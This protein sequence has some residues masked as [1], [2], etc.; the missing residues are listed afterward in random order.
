MKKLTLLLASVFGLVSVSM[1]HGFGHANINSYADAF[2]FD[3]MGVT[4]SVYPDGEFDF[5]LPQNQQSTTLSN[6]YVNVTFNSGYNYNPFVQYDD[7]GAVIQVEN[8]Q[9]WYDYYGRVSQIG[10]VRISYRDRR[11]CQVGGLY[12]HYNSYGHY[13]YH[14]GFINTWNPYFVY[15]PFY[16]AFARP[17]INLCFVRTNPYRQFYTPIRYT[18]YRPYVQNIR[19]CYATI[20]HTYR[21]PAGYGRVHHRYT[22]TAGRGEVPMVRS[23]RT[24]TTADASP[25]PS[26]MNRAA[27]SNQRAAVNSTNVRTNNGS[28]Q[29]Q[30]VPNANSGRSIQRT[31]EVR[32]PVATQPR[33]VQSAPVRTSTNNRVAP[34]TSSTRAATYSQSRGNVNAS[35]VSRPS[36]STSTRQA[37]PSRSAVSS[38][39]SRNSVAKAPT[40]S[41]TSTAR[42]QPS[43]SSRSSV[44]KPTSS[45]SSR[46]TVSKPTASPSSR[47]S[48]SQPTRSSSSVKSSGRNTSSS[49]AA[50]KLGVSKS[51]SSKRGN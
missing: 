4:F 22:Q 47:V 8:V 5:Y 18:Y 15:R 30:T 6:G 14:T 28:R 31:S 50:G 3:E 19:P 39:T 45:S 2:V 16:V 23:R 10:D 41:R 36:S 37:A 40:S 51:S 42:T 44:S 26:N 32:K 34:S 7:F 9:V 20:G 25:R 29:T 48:S 38:S 27:V 35:S 33:T 46:N 43:S 13:A 17:A 11:V 21:P 1:A 12:V 49:S 24:V